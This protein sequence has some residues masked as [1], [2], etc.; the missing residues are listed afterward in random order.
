LTATPRTGTLPT[1]LRRPHAPGLFI[2]VLT[3]ACGG[4][5]DEATAGGTSSGADSSSSSTTPPTGST[6]EPSS[7]EATGSST[8]VDPTTAADTS[9][10][11]STS[12]PGSSSSGDEVST[13][14]SS[15]GP[16]TVDFVRFRISSAAGPCPPMMDCNGFV[17]LL[18]DGLLR[19]E[20]FGDV[21]NPVTEVDVTPE[22]LDAAIVVFTD[23]ALVAL[24][25]GVDPVCDP[26]T[27]I[28]ESMEL[29]TSMM[30]HDASTTFCDQPPIA[31]ARDMAFALRDEYVP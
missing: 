17:E 23:P 24:L 19:V 6:A 1:M 26:P 12:E 11:T 16:D 27:D 4:G 10:S 2:L 8:A 14:D 3:L 28:F 5:G 9:T 20:K 13:G 25:D 7:S 21:N 29:E 31:A 18:A 30:I 15:T 22:D